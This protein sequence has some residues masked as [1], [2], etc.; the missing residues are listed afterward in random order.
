MSGERAL[1][2]RGVST[3]I[4]FLIVMT[5]LI[6][7]T[8]CVLAAQGKVAGRRALGL[9]DLMRQAERRQNQ[10][11]S[12]VYSENSSDNLRVYL[13]N[14]GSQEALAENIWLSGRPVDNSD[15]LFEQ[16][17]GS[18]WTIDPERR[19]PPNALTRVTIKN[20]W[21]YSLGYFAL[22]TD[23]DCLYAWRVG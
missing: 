19:L 4:G 12:F 2:R 7:F 17:A 1:G 14:F 16:A 22:L 6:G 15:I 5:A 9:M 21:K 20:L 8:T 10:L 11:I 13:Y 3:V 18:G 23:T